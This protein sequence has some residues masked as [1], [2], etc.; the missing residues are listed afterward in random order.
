LLLDPH[1]FRPNERQN[2][3][4]EKD[5]PNAP[6]FRGFT[7]VFGIETVPVHP[8]DDENT[9]C[10]ISGKDDGKEIRV[11]VYA[12]FRLQHNIITVCQKFVNRGRK[13]LKTASQDL[14]TTG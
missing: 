5:T 12:V 1:S 3:R 9:A 2:E 11:H 6:F 8:K 10:D 14:Y 7:A 4:P 13:N